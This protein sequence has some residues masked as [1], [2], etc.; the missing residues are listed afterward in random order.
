VRRRRLSIVPRRNAVPPRVRTEVVP[1][2][3]DNPEPEVPARWRL[4]RLQEISPELQ[5]APAVLLRSALFRASNGVHW[6]ALDH[7]R[8]TGH[9]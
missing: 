3:P 9:P 1:P 5:Q 6:H 2:T 4:L 7:G 8:S